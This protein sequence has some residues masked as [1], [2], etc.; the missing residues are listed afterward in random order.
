MEPL[1]PLVGTPKQVAWAES[2]RTRLVAKIDE[3]QRACE[4]NPQLQSVGYSELL[5]MQVERQT[6]LF[7]AIKLKDRASW[8]IDRREMSV[9]QLAAEEWR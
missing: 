9:E 8:W 2:I 4:A 1:P 3:H 6:R 7:A 5:R